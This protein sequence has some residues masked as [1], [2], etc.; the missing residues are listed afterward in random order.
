MITTCPHH[1]EQKIQGKS[2][3]YLKSTLIFFGRPHN[4]THQQTQ[5]RASRGEGEVAGRGKAVAAEEV[6]GRGEV[7]VRH[8]PKHRSAGLHHTGSVERGRTVCRVKL[9]LMTS[10][11]NLLDL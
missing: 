10:L 1:N 2:S 11:L 7:A 6:V 4:K 8:G 9:I 3:H 5:C